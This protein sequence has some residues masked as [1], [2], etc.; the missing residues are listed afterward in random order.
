MV[1][2]GYLLL[3]AEQARRPYRVV[4]GLGALLLLALLLYLARTGEESSDP[5]KTY[6]YPLPTLLPLPPTPPAGSGFVS[7]GM[8]LP[9]DWLPLYP[10]DP[11]AYPQFADLLPEGAD[12]ATWANGG[13]FW[14]QSGANPELPQLP[15]WSVIIELHRFRFCGVPEPYPAKPE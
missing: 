7:S 14:V 9:E 4:V 15:P 1:S 13:L 12:C 6:P 10:F 3:M 2:R 8:S 11:P 5:A